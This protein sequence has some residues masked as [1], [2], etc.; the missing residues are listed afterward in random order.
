MKFA[1]SP[2]TDPLGAALGSR[3]LTQ[4]PKPELEFVLSS[5]LNLAVS[6][7]Q[8]KDEA[9]RVLELTEPILAFDPINVQVHESTC[10]F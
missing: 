1:R 4:L 2:R 7:L 9:L 6:Y 8:S 5:Q 10:S 3:T